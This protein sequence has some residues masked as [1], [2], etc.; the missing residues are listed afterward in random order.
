MF[1]RTVFVS[2]IILSAIP[3]WAN[4]PEAQRVITFKEALSVAQENWFPSRLII[5]SEGNI[6]VYSDLDRTLLFFNSSGRE[7]SR[8]SFTKGQGPGEFNGFDPA[9]SPDGR[10]FVADWPQRRITIFGPDLNLVNIEKM[11]LYGDQF[12]L[13]SKGN[14][15]FL[16]YQAA[17][18]RAR[19]RVVLT[20]C[21]PSGDIIKEITD[22]E[23]GPRQRSDGTYETD[24]FPTQLKYALDAQDNVVYAFSNEYKIFIIS[25]TGE[26][27]RTIIRDVKPRKV[28]KEDVDRLLPDPS[29]D[30]GYKHLIPDRVP[31]IAGLFALADGCLLVVTFEK[32]AV[33]GFLAGDLFDVNGRYIATVPVPKY[34]HWDFLLSPQKSWAA[35]WKE[36]FYTIESDANEEKRWVK[37]YRIE[38]K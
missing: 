9:F 7:L 28:E 38:W 12:R 27:V 18:S 26:I 14:R 24:L 34:Y 33:E 13:D 16:A 11:K 30:V 35:L 31:A 4:P 10:L 19:N 32:A 36:N 17:S 29:K 3:A 25:P 5:D 8:R 15:Y 23:W 1:H 20:K 6:C 21:T 22:Y 2:L 37:C